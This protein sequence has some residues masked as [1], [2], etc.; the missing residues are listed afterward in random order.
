MPSIR[1]SG[2][3]TAFLL[4]LVSVLCRESARPVI[5]YEVKNPAR[6]VGHEDLP[7]SVQIVVVHTEPG[8]PQLFKI[9][10]PCRVTNVRGQYV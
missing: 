10:R 8:G 9:I 5:S 2:S 6:K 3:L 4:W 7:G 1:T